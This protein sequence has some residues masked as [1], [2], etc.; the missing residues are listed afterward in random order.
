MKLPPFE[1]ASPA[2]ATEVIALLGANRGTA[3]IIAGGQSLLPTM[4]YRL[5][6]PALL[7]DLKNVPELDRIA[8]DASGVRLGA[9]SRWRDI[10]DDVRLAVA[11]PLLREAVGHVAHYQVRNR[12]T[13]GGSIAH[14]DP[15]S[16]FPGIAVICDAVIR[17]LGPDG[18]RLVPASNFFVGPL[19][20]TLADDEMVLEIQ[21]PPWPAAR[22]WSFEEFSRRAGDFALAGVG[23][24]Y[25]LGERGEMRNVHIGVIG[26]CERPMRLRHAESALEGSMGEAVEIALACL[27]AS[28][29]ADPGPDMH[30]DAGY[31]KALVATLLERALHRAAIRHV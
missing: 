27:M 24:F 29:E 28:G 2:C 12:G 31:R 20:T 23:L 9:R 17:L 22:R 6:Q 21:F 25:D 8:V 10:E 4:A 5:A 15:A 13:V 30:A 11:H 16:E 26:A 18:E 1:Y 7:V 14:A 19:T 3:K